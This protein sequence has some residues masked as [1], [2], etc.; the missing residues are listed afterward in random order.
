MTSLATLA[1][2]DPVLARRWRIA[3]AVVAAADVVAFA[4]LHG[5]G[6]R[7]ELAQAGAFA[8]AI[9]TAVVALRG[10]AL[11]RPLATL[12]VVVALAFPLRAGVLSLLAAHVSP[13]VAIVPAAL[14]GALTLLLGL[15]AFAEGAQARRPGVAALLAI[16][17]LLVLRLVYLGQVELAP[18]EAYYWNYAQHLDIG[19]LDHPPLVAWLDANLSGLSGGPSD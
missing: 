12:V 1:H 10:A 3:V 7:L 13:L 15:A 14:A 17:Y 8:L 6:V 16:G 19:Y 4:L 18:Q 11:P 9:A 5:A 2:A